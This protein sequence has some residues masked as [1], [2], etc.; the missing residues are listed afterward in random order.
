MAKGEK[1]S[2]EK[3]K[4]TDTSS[5]N[6]A[7]SKNQSLCLKTLFAFKEGMFLFYEEGKAVSATLLRYE[8]WSVS[9]IKT[10]E[11][12]HYNAIQLACRP[13]KPSRSNKAEKGHLRS[14]GFV[15]GAAFIREVRCEE[16]P[17]E[18]RVGQTLALD[19]FQKG[20]ILQISSVSKGRGFAGTVRRYDFGGGPAAHGSTF[21]RQPGSIGGRASQGRVSRGKKM[22][23]HYGSKIQTFKGIQLMGLSVGKGL[24]WVKGSVPGARQTLVKLTKSD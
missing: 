13:K 10:L 5:A 8:P 14:A 6:D 24:L 22:P 7:S 11:K 23:G 12:D 18:A 21:H 15:N 16:I 20:D 17:E 9:Q 4:K 19:S 1:L 3:A 2:E